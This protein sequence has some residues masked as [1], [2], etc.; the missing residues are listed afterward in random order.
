M[1]TMESGDTS[2]KTVGKRILLPKW[3]R[4]SLS[5]LHTAVRTA[6]PPDSH[7]GR[8]VG[9]KGVNVASVALSRSRSAHFNAAAMPGC[10]APR[11]YSDV[12]APVVISVASEIFRS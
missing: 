12:V 2:R 3:L 11:T 9:L 4:R 10:L 7:P 5:K 6:A 8:L 1:V